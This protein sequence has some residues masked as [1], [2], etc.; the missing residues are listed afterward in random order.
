MQADKSYGTTHPMRFLLL[1]IAPFIGSFLGVLIRRLPRGETVGMDRSHCETCH[2]TL[3]P[4][5]LI[6]LLSYIFQRG[7][8]RSCGARVDPFHPAI[9]LAATVIAA[10]ALAVASP[11]SPFIGGTVL[12]GWALLTLS[13]IDLETF[14]LPDALTLPLLLCGLVEGC[15]IPNGPSLESR[16]AGALA[17]W[18]LL[19]MVSAVYKAV[20]GRPGLGGGDA[21]LLAAGGA[22][23]GVEALPIV[24]LG[25]SV[26]GFILA[27]ILAARG[28]HLHARMMLPFG[29][30]LALSLWITRLMQHAWGWL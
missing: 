4:A 1:V 13:W 11:N 17:G 19:T 18:M 16:V 9:E 26:C 6:P 14:L 3:G 8:C 28:R 21:K 30:C 29:P 20:R 7:R 2:Q 22:W 27:L 23:V 25:A 10:L 15:M 12:L 5:E 24:L